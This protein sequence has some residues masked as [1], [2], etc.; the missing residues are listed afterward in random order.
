MKGKNKT[1]AEEVLLVV[2]EM[3]DVFFDGLPKTVKINSYLPHQKKNSVACTLNRLKKDG[4]IEEVLVENKEVYRL[5]DKGKLRIF[6]AYANL[7]PSWDGKWRIVIFDI[8]EN[9]KKSREIFRS[10]L[11][12]LGFKMVQNSVWICPHDIQSVI[13]MMTGYYNINEYVHFIVADKLS[14]EQKFIK[15]FDLNF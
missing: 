11:K 4:Y 10:K 6:K 13:K 12:E 14:G 5:T 7:K 2:K 8:P 9:K 15:E 3:A 1:L